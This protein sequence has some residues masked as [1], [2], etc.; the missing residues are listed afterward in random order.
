MS[1]TTNNELPEDRQTKRGSEFNDLLADLSPR[2]DKCKG[3]IYK[4]D[5]QHCRTE[6]GILFS[7]R[8]N[9][10][11]R[12]SCGGCKDCGAI[13]D[14]L[15]EIDPTIWPIL[16]IEKCKH[17]EL[18]TLEYCNISTDWETGYADSWDLRAA[19]YSD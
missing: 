19:K 3:A 13:E 8:L 14:E 7:V 12:M 16:D 9:K 6:R 1:E 10:M 5:V 4:V 18:Y 15:N 2:Q 11:K 17:G